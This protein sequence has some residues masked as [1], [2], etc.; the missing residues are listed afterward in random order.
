MQIHLLWYVLA[1]ISLIVGIVYGILAYTNT[2][3]IDGD[4]TRNIQAATLFFLAAIGLGVLGVLQQQ[5][6]V[7]SYKM[8]YYKKKHGKVAVANTGTMAMTGHGTQSTVCAQ[9]TMY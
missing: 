5:R 1:I 7:W 6:D 3:L 9:K 2:S 4:F 8:D